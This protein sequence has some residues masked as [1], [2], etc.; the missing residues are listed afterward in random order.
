M[1]P[2]PSHHRSPWY[3]SAFGDLYLSLYAHRNQD[4]ARRATRFLL[5]ENIA[6][7]GEPG[8]DLCCGPARHLAELLEARLHVIGIDLSAPL[9]NAAQNKLHSLYLPARLVRGSMDRLPLRQ[10]FGWVIN[11]FTSFGYFERDEDN[12]RV[13]QEAARVLA[14]GGRFLMD[15]MNAPFIRATLRP[16]SQ[17][18]P[19]PGFT[20]RS[21]R[22]IEGFPPR[23]VKRSHIEY[24]RRHQEVI[25]SVRL[26]EH[27]ELTAMFEAAGLRVTRSWG[28]FGDRRWGE[29]AP[30][31]IL[32]GEKT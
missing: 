27:H 3:K 14:P 26:F 25:E 18:Q 15:F 32:L 31:C 12:A 5:R 11:L 1:P 28:D 9:L 22:A 13:I 19:A 30:R 29:M 17:G 21:T 16:A 10:G 7:P 8:L 2:S 24:D 4:D 23:V 6:R 20:V